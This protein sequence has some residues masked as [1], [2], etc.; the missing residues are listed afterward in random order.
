MAKYLTVMLQPSSSGAMVYAVIVI[1]IIL[2]GVAVGLVY[3]KRKNSNKWF[4]TNKGPVD[5][6]DNIDKFDNLKQPIN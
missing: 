3:T 6:K 4:I 5:S 1:S 2:L